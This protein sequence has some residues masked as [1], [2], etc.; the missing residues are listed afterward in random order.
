MQRRVTSLE[1]KHIIIGN[2]KQTQQV[3]LLQ[4]YSIWCRVMYII[5]LYIY[6]IFVTNYLLAS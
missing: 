4:L 5:Y 2:K 1:M 3:N 6:R